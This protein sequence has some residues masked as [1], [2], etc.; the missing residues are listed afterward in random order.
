LLGSWISSNLERKSGM[1]G[2]EIYFVF[3]IDVGLFILYFHPSC[4]EI[5][6]VFCIDVGLGKTLQ[7]SRQDFAK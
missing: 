6:F 5:Y 2:I 1:P 7:S 3:C 4:I